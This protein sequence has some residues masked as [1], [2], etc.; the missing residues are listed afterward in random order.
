M[1]DPISIEPLEG[2]WVIRAGGAVLGET[3]SALNVTPAGKETAVYFPR[4][5]IAMAMFEPSGTKAVDPS[6]GQATYYSLPTKSVLIEDAG[7]SY[8]AP[9]AGYQQLSGHL[10]FFGDKVVVEQT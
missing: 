7:W 6:M 8:E 4:A 2:T 10:A 9:P 5:D 1:T 3:Q